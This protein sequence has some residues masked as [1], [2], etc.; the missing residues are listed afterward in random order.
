MT[1]SDEGGNAIDAISFFFNRSSIKD[2][3]ELMSPG[4]FLTLDAALER[5]YFGRKKELRLRVENL[6]FCN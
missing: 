4:D 5:S 6:E 2:V 1:V 3:I